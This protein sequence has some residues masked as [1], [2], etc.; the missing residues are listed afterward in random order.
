MDTEYD[1]YKQ[2]WEKYILWL[3]SNILSTT[4]C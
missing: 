1:P 4:L 2:N 3:E